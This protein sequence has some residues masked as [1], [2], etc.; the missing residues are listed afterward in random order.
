[1]AAA[2]LWIALYLALIT[3]PL[4]VLLVAPAPPGRGFVW[5]LSIALGFAGVVMTGLQFVITARFRRATAPYGIDIIYYFH[6]YAAA[7]AFAAIVAHPLLVV[8]DEPAYLSFLNPVLAPWHM[9]AGVASVL[10]LSALVL[11][12][13]GR[14]RLHIHYDGWRRAHLLLAVAAVGLAVAHIHGARYY[15]A[16]PPMSVLWPVLVA[17]WLAVA[18]YVRVI[19][20]ALVMRSPYRVVEVRRERG[21]AWTVVLT[22]RDQRGLAFEP[23]QFVWLSLR[24]APFAMRDHPFS[25]S[26]SPI[27]PR[28]VEVTIKELGDFTRTIK[29]LVPGEVAYVDGP[30]GAFTIDRY[31]PPGFVF[32][33]GGIGIAPVMSMLR[34]LHDRGDQRQILLIYAYRRWERLTFREVLDDLAQRMRMRV[35]YVLEEP[36]PGWSG[37]KGR[38]TKELLDLELP[39]NRVV[40]EYFVCGPEPMIHAIENALYELGI[41]LER[42]HSELFDLV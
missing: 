17:V 20:P 34:A 26:S 37:P 11:S 18:V 33:A 1:M 2:F 35:V 14:K 31:D 5:D 27:T 15:T 40:L 7:V 21:D 22:P 19:R 41:P 28:R 6:R 29:D 30:Y 9:T 3:A 10:A 25:L 24:S 42:A 23:G 13:L 36:P 4:L 8:A 39:L 32:I 12:S 16:A 38:I